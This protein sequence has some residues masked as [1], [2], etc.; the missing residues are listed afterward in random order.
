MEF[1]VAR[2]DIA[3]ALQV[4]ETLRVRLRDGLGVG[5]SQPMQDLH[6]RLLAARQ[7]GVEPA[8]TFR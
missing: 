2:E 6:R 8:S 5:P 7:P 4:Y 3:S 1:F